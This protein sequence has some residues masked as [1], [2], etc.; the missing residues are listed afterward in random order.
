MHTYARCIYVCTCQSNDRKW[1][2]HLI[3]QWTNWRGEW[4]LNFIFLVY[5]LNKCELSDN[6]VMWSNNKDHCIIII[7]MLYVFIYII[8]FICSNYCGLRECFIFLSSD[9]HVRTNIQH[10]YVCTHVCVRYA[11][12]CTLCCYAQFVIVISIKSEKD[13]NLI[14]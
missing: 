13:E 11:Y 2:T 14:N 7:F 4:I 9:W 10:A 6:V 1:N 5:Y 12:V 3:L 8:I